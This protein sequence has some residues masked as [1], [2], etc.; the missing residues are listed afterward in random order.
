MLEQEMVAFRFFGGLEKKMG[1]VSFYVVPKCG[2][3]DP[4]VNCCMYNEICV[5]YVE[6]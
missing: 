1:T 3:R 6:E 4:T 2:V 5:T